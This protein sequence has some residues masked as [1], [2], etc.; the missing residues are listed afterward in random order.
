ME[1]RWYSQYIQV[2]ISTGQVLFPSRKL[3]SK[4]QHFPFQSY[5]W[6]ALL[7]PSSKGG[8]ELQSLAGPDSSAHSSLGK[9]LMQT[10][11]WAGRFS[12]PQE[13]QVSSHCW[14]LL[15]ESFQQSWDKSGKSNYSRATVLELVS[16]CTGRQTLLNY[17]G[18]SA[19]RKDIANQ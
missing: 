12:R 8:F 14:H 16:S 15:A 5:P 19:A 2:H 10:G 9:S 18:N 1:H 4:F 6:I 11:T 7:I 17:A 3:D 13:A